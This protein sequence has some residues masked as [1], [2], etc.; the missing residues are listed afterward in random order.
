[1]GQLKKIF[2][3]RLLLPL[4]YSGEVINMPEDVIGIRGELGKI[5]YSNYQFFFDNFENSNYREISADGLLHSKSD[6]AFWRV[7]IN[8]TTFDIIKW[9]TPKRTRSYPLARCYSLLSS[10]NQKVSAIPIVKDE[11]AK[12][13]NPDVLGIDSICL[14][15]LFDIYVVLS[16]YDQAEKKL[17][18]NMKGETVAA[19]TNQK[20]NFYIV[21]DKLQAIH[22]KAF[23]IEEWNR[24]EIK[25]YAETLSSAGRAYQIIQQQT[26]VVLPT[27]RRIQRNGEFISQHGIE[28]FIYRADRRKRRSQTSELLTIQ[29]KEKI[30]KIGKAKLDIIL[31]YHHGLNQD[32]EIHWTPDESWSIDGNIVIVEKKDNPSKEDIKEAFFRNLAIQNMKV[33]NTDKQIHFAIGITEPKTDTIC[34]SRCEFFD[35]CSTVDWNIPCKYFNASKPDFSGKEFLKLALLEANKNCF[36]LFTIG[37]KGR[38][39]ISELQEQIL[40]YI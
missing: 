17:R 13:K 15:T 6:E 22:E 39:N 12:S 9:T 32:I 11:G 3:R 34:F 24:L 28:G 23:T 19:I 20:L 8:H 31:K 37:T 14:L 27:I 4:S 26:G 36:F 16:Y 40:T 38:N 21:I 33:L 35:N 1:M 5:D 29:P 2:R 10:P 18:V 25:N 7:K 30:L